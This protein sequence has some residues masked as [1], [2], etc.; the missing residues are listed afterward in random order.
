[1][2]IVLAYRRLPF[3]S[4]F[5]RIGRDHHLFDGTPARGAGANRRTTDEAEGPVVK[6][7]GIEF[8]DDAQSGGA[9]S[10]E[11]VDLDVL[12]EIRSRLAHHLIC[13]ILADDAF[14][15]RR[16]VGDADS[17]QQKQSDVV[18]LK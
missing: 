18:E 10:N 6:M 13:V 11:R 4:P 7:V 8:I 15:A 16:I 12:G 9:G 14:A 3:L 17:G 1:M 5:W 2:A